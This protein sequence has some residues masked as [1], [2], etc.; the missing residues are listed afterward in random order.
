MPDNCGW[1]DSP[2]PKDI[3]KADLKGNTERLRE[4]GFVNPRN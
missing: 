3:Y 1:F 2:G 4:L